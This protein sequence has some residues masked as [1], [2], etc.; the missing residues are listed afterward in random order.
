MGLQ[1]EPGEDG[2][3]G[4]QGPRGAPGVPGSDTRVCVFTSPS[5]PAVGDQLPEFYADRDLTLEYVQASGAA[6]V[7]VV[8][9]DLKING[10]SAF[11]VTTKP[12]APAAGGL[13]TRRVPD[14]TA[15]MQG[16][17]LTISF[18]SADFTDADKIL[19]YIGAH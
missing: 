19:V 7:A 11:P 5:S 2:S 8:T 4:W 12:D 14:T 6:R 10:T 18:S 1:G 13:G 17:R 15:V 9:I 16:D 3:D